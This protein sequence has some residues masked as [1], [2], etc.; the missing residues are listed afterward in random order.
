MER[1]GGWSELSQSLSEP[2]D[3]GAIP[4]AK[5]DAVIQNIVE[6]VEEELKKY[7]S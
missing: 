1:W 6:K 2:Q 5:F 7:R 3:E 4:K